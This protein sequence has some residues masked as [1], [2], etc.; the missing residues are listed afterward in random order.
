[1]QARSYQ[2]NPSAPILNATSTSSE[3]PMFVEMLEYKRLWSSAK[4]VVETAISGCVRASGSGQ[5][6]VG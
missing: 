2:S 4:H 6:A 5:K 3:L 1:M